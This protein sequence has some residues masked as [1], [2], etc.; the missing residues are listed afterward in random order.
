MPPH[1]PTPATVFSPGSN[2]TAVF[3]LDCIISARDLR[4]SE[5]LPDL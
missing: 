1:L 2:I 5:V 4:V 3:S